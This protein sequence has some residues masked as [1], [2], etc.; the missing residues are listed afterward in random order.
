MKRQRLFLVGAVLLGLVPSFAMGQ[1]LKG[2]PLQ[3]DSIVKRVQEK[4]HIPALAVT[5]V[6]DGKTVFADGFGTLTTKTD[7]PKADAYTLFVNAST[8]KA[9]TAALLAMMVEKG[10]VQWTDPVVKHLPDFQ[11]Y[12]PYVTQDYRVQDIMNHIVGFQAQALDEMPALGYDRDEL[13][14]MLR[15]IKPSY[16]FRDTYA[17]CNA[18]FTVAARIVEKYTGMTWEEALKTYIYTP[19]QMEHSR[20]GKDGYFTETN[21]AYG[22]RLSKTKNGLVLSP[23]DDREETYDWLQAVS[24]AAFV[25]CNA[26]D[27]G[28]W[29]RMWL[30]KGTFTD[31]AGKTVK[32]LD[33]SSVDFLFSPQTIC[34]WDDNRVVL[35]AQAWRIEQGIQGKLINHTGLAGGYTAW[36]VLV[37]EL[38][39]GVSILANQGSTTYPHYA[40]GRSV[41]DLY[42]G[43]SSD[44]TEDLFA[45]YMSPSGGGSR[46]QKEEPMAALAN[47][48][49][50]GRYFKEILGEAQVYEKNGGL[51]IRIKDIDSPLKHV[52]GHT[53][54][55]QARSENMRM[56]FTINPGTGCADGFSL[57]MDNDL[58]PF[59][60]VTQP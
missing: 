17:Y 12:D 27:M 31:D 49:Y 16:P 41:I 44:W 19:L 48:A 59:V 18:P 32:V 45:E 6:K 9:F 60:R 14:R 57:D 3:I 1:N 5:V 22:Y 39:L 29:M 52:N 24:P 20:T 23:R 35:Y 50:V 36:V 15:L 21:F 53:F 10:Y 38:N 4:W 25:M 42:R 28:N 13:Y 11:L 26:H 55:F 56:T 8:S 40:I 7:A 43:V 2:Q 54:R 37:P 58:G 51:F 34:S 47:A 33:P 46:P 30:G